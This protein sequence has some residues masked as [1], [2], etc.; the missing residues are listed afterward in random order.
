MSKKMSISMNSSSTSITVKGL[1][2]TS[3]ISGVWRLQTADDGNGVIQTLATLTGNKPEGV[4]V[5][6]QLSCEE[7]IIT[8]GSHVR[9]ELTPGGMVFLDIKGGKILELSRLI[10]KGDQ[11]SLEFGMET[12]EALFGTGERFNGVNQRGRKVTVW[13]EDRWCH[14]E[15]NSYLPIP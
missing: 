14:T 10:Q 3:P 11:V 1:I 7:K 8:T 6:Q 12:D 2:V 13:A 9:V 15:G 4:N 5:E